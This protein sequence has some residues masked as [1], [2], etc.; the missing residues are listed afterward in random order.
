MNTQNFWQKQKSAIY[1]GIFILIIVS[2]F[3]YEVSKAGQ[4]ATNLITFTLDKIEQMQGQNNEII[5]LSATMDLKSENY[6]LLIKKINQKSLL[7]ENIEILWP[8]SDFAQNT[9]NF[10]SLG[11]K[12][13]ESNWQNWQKNLIP[14]LLENQKTVEDEINYS[15]ISQFV[16]EKNVENLN[17]SVNSGQKYLQNRLVRAKKILNLDKQ[18][19][20]VNGLE[21]SKET[22]DKIEKILKNPENTKENQN[23]EQNWQEIKRILGQNPVEIEKSIEIKVEQVETKEFLENIDQIN[24]NTKSLVKEYKLND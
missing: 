23:S 10:Q 9:K 6:Q 5:E 3:F 12:S 2:L 15:K 24:K 17:I 21:K 22:L 11:Q 20:L 7:K 19:P 18:I 4:K 1:F 13:I 16:D 8:V 14:S